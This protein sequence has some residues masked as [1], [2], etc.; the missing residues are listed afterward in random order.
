M[1]KVN[2]SGINYQGH[3]SPFQGMGQAY[4]ESKSITTFS[5]TG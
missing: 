2:E 5:V 1:L 3:Y 4:L